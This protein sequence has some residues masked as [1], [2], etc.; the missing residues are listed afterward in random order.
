MYREFIYLDTDRVQ[1]IIA[2]LEEGLLTQVISGK[3]KEVTGKLSLAA[4]VLAQFLPVGLEG[5]AKGGSSIQHSKVLHDYAYEVA[6]NSLRDSEM[7]FEVSYGRDELFLPDTAFV[8][9]KGSARILDYKELRNLSE[10]G[11][12]L[13]HIFSG[14]ISAEPSETMNRQQRRNLDKHGQ[15]QQKDSS[16]ASMFDEIKYFIDVFY[17]DIIQF[18]LTNIADLTFTG[19]LDR[20]FLREEIRNLIFKFGSTPKGEW[21]M[22]AQISTIPDEFNKL[23]NLELLSNINIDPAQMS[24]VSDFMSPMIQMINSLQEFISSV[25]YPNVAV[26]PIAIYR[27]LE[28]GN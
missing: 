2:Q 18:E 3:Q 28:K 24:T 17:R 23:E 14:N 6:L 4:S 12:K 20:N 9:V 11:D 13:G 7:L 19:I 10:H 15:K 1:S 22:L 8:L 5:S 21:F 27:Q 25:S 16:K 26:S